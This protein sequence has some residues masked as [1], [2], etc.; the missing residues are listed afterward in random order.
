[1][2]LQQAEHN[3]RLSDHLLGLGD[4]HDWVVTTAFYSA[5]HFVEHKIFP[6][7]INGQKFQTFEEYYDEESKRKNLSKHAIKAN[8][9]GQRLP[10]IKRQYGWLKDACHSARYIDYKVSAAKAKSANATLKVLKSCC[11]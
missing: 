9:V 11:V 8:L 10:G 4:F 6:A 3:E 7:T 1:M 5:I 2:R